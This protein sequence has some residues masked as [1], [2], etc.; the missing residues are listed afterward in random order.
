MMEIRR[1]AGLVLTLILIVTASCSDDSDNGVQPQ[2]SPYKAL[3]QKDHVLFNLQLAYTNRNLAEFTKLLDEGFV[4][5]FSQA[6]FKD[7]SVGVEQW[8]VDAELASVVNMFDEN[9]SKPGVDPI[10]KID[11]TLKYVE[12]DNAWNPV[13]P[14]D[15]TT[16]PDETWYEKT[17]SYNLICTAGYIDYTGLNILASFIVRQSTVEGKTIW[18]II[19]WRDDTLNRSARVLQGGPQGALVEDSTWGKVKALYSN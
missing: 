18:R 7:G 2:P 3:T 13:T 19:S 1:L 14:D 5:H 10:S 6:D 16:Y 8:E 12:G 4:F 15:Q 9:F 17:V 11:L